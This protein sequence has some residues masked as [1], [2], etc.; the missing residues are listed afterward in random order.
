MFNLPTIPLSQWIENITQSATENGEGFFNGVRIL[1][2]TLIY[3]LTDFFN[4]FPPFVFILAMTLWAL[5]LQNNKKKWAFPVFVFLGLSF[6]LN[7]GLW[8]DFMSTLSLILIASLFAILLG[9]P[10][11]ILMGKSNI[12]QTILKPVLDFMQTMPAF[13]YLI[14]AVAFFGIGVVPGMVASII[15]SIPPTVRFTALG[16]RQ[17][18]EELEEAAI[19]F[20][21]TPTQKLFKVELRLA[22]S[23]IMAGVNQTIML[24]LSMV[25]IASMI[26]SP[27]LGRRVVSALQRA[28]VGPGFVAG[29]AIVILAIIIDRFTHLL[30]TD[31]HLQ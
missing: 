5:Y 21:A 8:G 4:L 9:I 20:G 14:P 17:I 3:G 25:V 7:Q 31:K 13:V 30:S 6:I 16:I 2:D 1:G 11:G 23:T 26:G 12:A 15:F 24:C 19:S 29:L 10:L 22:K 27:G 18:S 28:Q